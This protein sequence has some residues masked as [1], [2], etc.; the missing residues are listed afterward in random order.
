MS[1]KSI[2]SFLALAS[3]VAAQQC[4][5]QFDGRIAMNATAALF[6]TSASPFNPSNVFGQS[7]SYHFRSRFEA[8]IL[9]RSYI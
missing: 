9:D 7:E 1:S 5:L 8:E 3:S 4:P 6:D 2:L